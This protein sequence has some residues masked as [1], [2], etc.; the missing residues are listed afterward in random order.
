MNSNQ[1]LA[2]RFSLL[3][4]I[5]CGLLLSSNVYADFIEESRTSLNIRNFYMSRDFRQPD[6]S[7]TQNEWAQGFLLNFESG[8]T[9]TPVGFGLDV[10]ASL[11]LKLD[12]GR[13]RS[14]DNGLLPQGEDGTPVNNYSELGFTGKLKVS[15]SVLRLGVMYPTIPVLMYN[16]GRLLPTSYSGGMVTSKEIEGLTFNAGRF[17]HSNQRN[18]SSTDRI[19]YY[20]GGVESDHFD[21]AGGSYEFSPTLTG[22]YY[23]SELDDIYKQHFS[24]FVHS[25]LLSELTSLRTDLRYFHSNDAGIAKMGRFDNRNLN[26]MLTLGHGAHKIAGAYQRVSGDGEFPFVGNDPYVVNLSFHNTFTR[27][28]MESW[29]LRYDYDFTGL[30]IPGLTFMTRYISGKNAVVDGR[31]RGREW[32]RNSDLSY[33]I[34][35]GPLKNVYFHVRNITFRSSNGLTRDVDENRLIVG[36]KL[37]V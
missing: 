16:F 35:S 27:E 6:S 24:G 10:H 19:T 36:Y 26:G 31:A 20:R 30:G 21:F 7:E 29:Q 25:W 8:F 23:Y 5:V 12:S 15:N 33:S 17:T 34:P 11:G 32:E 22:S 1:R 28:E 37:E 13:G 9:D 14:G 4:G 2:A 3:P 18:S